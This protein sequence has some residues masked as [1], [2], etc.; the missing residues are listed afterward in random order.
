MA[1]A[2]KTVTH[3]HELPIEYRERQEAQIARWKRWT[4][5]EGGRELPTRLSTLMRPEQGARIMW[6]QAR[7]MGTV[8]EVGCNWG[9]ILANCRGQAGVD[10]NPDL[11]NMASILN[12]DAEFQVADAR[13]L[14]YPDKAFGTVMLPEVLEHLPFEDVERAVAEACRVARN[15]VLVTIPDGREER[16]DSDIARSPKHAWIAD[17]E[18]MNQVRAWLRHYG[19]PGSKHGE[20]GWDDCNSADIYT[21]PW[22]WLVD[23]WVRMR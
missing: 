9:F 21:A 11:V 20:H 22:F 23:Q 5:A 19:H 15:R 18:H 17:I 1:G 10:V 2:G 8:L 4:A 16:G 13:K 6:L 7:K 14:P 3:D 12:P